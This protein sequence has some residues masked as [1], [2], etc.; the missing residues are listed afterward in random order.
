MN[1]SSRL[2]RIP[3]WSWVWFI[4]GTLY[5]LLP[6]YATLDFSLQMERDVIGFKAYEKAFEDKDFIET[7]TYSNLLAIATIVMSIVLIVPTSR[8]LPKRRGRLRK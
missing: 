5:F 3:F 4:L 8:L 2:R 6:L 7:F 1:F